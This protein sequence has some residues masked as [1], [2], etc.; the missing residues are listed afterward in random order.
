MNN[1]SVIIQ[2][3]MNSNRL[4]GKVLRKIDN[5]PII[6]FLINRINKSELIDNIIVATSNNLEDNQIVDQCKR[7]KINYF[8]GSENNVLSRYYEASIKFNLKSIVRICADSPFIDHIILDKMI[9]NFFD[10]SS[11]YDYLSNTLNQTYPVGMNIEIFTHSSL[12]QAFLNSNQKYQ[13]EHVT[14]YIYENPNLFNLGQE[15]LSEDYSSIRI[16]LDEE[17]DYILINKIFENIK[18]KKIE[19]GLKEI[20][21]LYNSNPNLFKLNSHIKQK[22]IDSI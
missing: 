5:K 17:D 12:E 11:S 4:P 21:E 8:R 9:S 14:P 7:M 15:H 22:L 18:I 19:F 13:L 20:I 2:A 10:K 6:E 16:T 3:R 1:I